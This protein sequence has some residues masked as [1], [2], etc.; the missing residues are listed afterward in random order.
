MSN[1]QRA[2][3]EQPDL[4][5][6]RS[7]LSTHCSYRWVILA[8]GF[9]NQALSYPIWYA[10]PVFFVAMIEEFGWARG[11]TAAVFSLF[12]LSYAGFAPL[13]GRLTERLGPRVV[14]PI[15][16]ATIGLA[17]AGSAFL[18][19]LWQFYLLYGLIGGIGMGMSGWISN[20]TIV[21]RWFPR[22]VG[23]AAGLTSAGIGIAIFVLTPLVQARV[24]SVGWR[25]A[26]LELAALT[27]L[28][29]IPANLLL[30]RP[31][32]GFGLDDAAARTEAPRSAAP[33][34]TRAASPVDDL[35]VDRAWAGRVWTLRTA[36][37]TSRF[38]LLF[39]A[40]TLTSFSVQLIF[41]HQLAYLVEA[42]VDRGLAAFAAGL[43]GLTSIPTKLA[44]GLVSDR[45][46][47]EVTWTLF[48]G[49]LVAG[50]G[51]L[52]LAGLGPRPELAYV[53]P[54]LVGMG[55]SAA[56]VLAPAMAADVFK[57]PH[58]GAIFG[59]LAGSS[60]IGAALGAWSAG[61]IYDL[62]GSYS[63]AFAAA[64]TG[65]ALAAICGW[66][67][68]PRLVRRTP[69]ARPRPGPSPDPQRACSQPTRPWS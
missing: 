6:H 60:G 25:Q 1:E 69:G 8:L 40:F 68:A 32:P 26:Y 34:P 57:G 14:V 10:F 18:T 35:V 59:A 7:L 41:V 63:I 19:E 11:P 53:Y 4:I 28:G 44:G 15:G 56:S 45:L 33:R 52:V 49:M 31:L 43:V 17:L 29:V 61:A 30:Q 2:T 46:G 64:A 47:R 16:A 48:K 24:T 65:A 38:W 50:V 54:I 20:V 22:K 67:A 39:A 12:M 66:L 51:F 42:G 37:A 36:V 9:A 23:T 3:S 13:V 27:V 62:T 5:A 58:F 21:S 55:Y